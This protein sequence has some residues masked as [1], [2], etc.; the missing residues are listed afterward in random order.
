MMY[1]VSILGHVNVDIPHSTRV[2]IARMCGTSWHSGGSMIPSYHTR[3]LFRGFSVEGKGLVDMSWLLPYRTNKATEIAGST[4]PSQ[5]HL[6]LH[7]PPVVKQNSTT[8]EIYS[9]FSQ[10]PATF[11]TQMGIRHLWSGT[12]ENL[13]LCDG[14][15]YGYNILM[16]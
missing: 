4:V 15:T 11:E 13:L 10:L 7:Y 14:Y 16:G 12:G 9:W 3:V 8:S 5:Q 6:F 2:S 1:D